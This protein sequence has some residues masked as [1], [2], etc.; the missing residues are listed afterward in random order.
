MSRAHAL[1]RDEFASSAPGD[2]PTDQPIGIP[3]K[4][5]NQRRESR[6][7]QARILAL[8][9]RMTHDLAVVE[10]DEQADVVPSRADAHV[11]QVAHDMGAQ[12]VSVERLKSYSA[13]I[14]ATDLPSL[15]SS[16]IWRLRSSVKHLG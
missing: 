10:V 13:I 5:S 2:V 11:C 15:Q 14:S 16:T 1:T 9:R 12:R 3:S 7:H 6:L 4:Q 8:A